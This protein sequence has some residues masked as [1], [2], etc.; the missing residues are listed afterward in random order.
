MGWAFGSDEATNILLENLETEDGPINKEFSDMLPSSPLQQP[1]AAANI[2]RQSPAAASI[3]RQ[4]PAPANISRQPPAPANISRQS[5]APAN[6]SRQPSGELTL[7]RQPSGEVTLPQKP[8][9]QVATMSKPQKFGKEEIAELKS[10]ME[11]E[12]EKVT[13]ELAKSLSE[14]TNLLAMKKSDKTKII[15]FFITVLMKTTT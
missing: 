12:I 4:P 15:D 7:P 14:A 2:S 8:S 13:P 3:S 5:P 11:A 10:T 9:G 1:P 6:I